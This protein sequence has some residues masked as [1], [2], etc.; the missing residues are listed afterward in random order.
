MSTSYFRRFRMEIDLAEVRL[1]RPVL[2]RGYVWLPWSFALLDRHASVKFES[3]RTEV[4]ARV[5]P[6]LG[7]PAGCQRLM[8]EI[9]KQKTFLPEATWMISRVADGQNSSGDCGTIQGL[10]QTRALG[11]VQ[12]VGVAPEHRGLGLGRALVVK[13]LHGFRRAYLR[14]V[15]LEVTADNEPAVELYRSLGFR[16]SRTMYKAVEAEVAQPV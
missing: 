13:A 2:P 11:A 1:P 10:A 12:N 4:D 16:I 15:Y 6:C 8:F 9:T 7:D 14:R 5:F 3:F